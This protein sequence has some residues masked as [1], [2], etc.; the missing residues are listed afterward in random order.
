MDMVGRGCEE[1]R[2]ASF[3]IANAS[4]ATFRQQDKRYKRLQR[5]EK[6]AEG[7]GEDLAMEVEGLW[8]W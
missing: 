1:E 7:S 8:M 2:L 6:N 5:T 3:S 4:N